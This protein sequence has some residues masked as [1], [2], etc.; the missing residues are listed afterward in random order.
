MEAIID[1]FSSFFNDYFGLVFPTIHLTDVVEV[2]II[3]WF[4]YRILVW[5]RD[6]RAWW[7][8]RGLIAIAVFF[9]IA[10]VLQMDTILW[11]G[12]RLVSF[13]IVAIAIIFQPELRNAL[14]SLGRRNFVEAVFSFFGLNRTVGKRF[15]DR[16]ISEIVSACFE[17]AAVKTGALIVVEQR[18][19]L[20]DCERTGIPVDANVS[21]QLLVNIFEKNTPLHDGAVIIRGDRVVAAT[22]YLPLTDN[23]EL[24]K[25][26]GTRHRAAVGISEVSDSLT[27]VVSEETGRVSV[28]QGGKLLSD[29]S[30]EGLSDILEHIQYPEKGAPKKSLFE[31]RPLS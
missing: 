7:L 5:I 29:F 11:L 8:F 2:F 30:A 3:T 1:S 21:R 28:A 6:T 16:T 18:V 13:G 20:S 19:K 22:C 9:I 12:E 31:R 4:F 10:A 17:M 23:L 26:L 25:D 15:E 14:E 24:S 27:I